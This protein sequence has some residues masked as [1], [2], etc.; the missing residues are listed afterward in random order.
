MLQLMN[1]MYPLEMRVGGMWHGD[2]LIL[3]ELVT[4]G[5]DAPTYNLSV[6]TDLWEGVIPSETVAAI[7]SANGEFD[8]T[9]QNIQKNAVLDPTG[10]KF[11]YPTTIFQDMKFGY[12]EYVGVEIFRDDNKDCNI[13][14][15]YPGPVPPGEN[16]FPLNLS[17]DYRVGHT[18]E[19]H[20]GMKDSYSA[21]DVGRLLNQFWPDNFPP[22]YPN[23]PQPAMPPQPGPR[24]YDTNSPNGGWSMTN[25]YGVGEAIYW[26]SNANY[27]ID[28]GDIRMTDVTVQRGTGANFAENVSYKRGSIVTAGDA[29]VMMNNFPPMPFPPYGL[30]LSDFV[31][32]LQD[33]QVVFWPCYYD[34]RIEDVMNPGHFLP[35]NGVYD[36][37]E[38]I[39]NCA[40]TGLPIV[41]PGF[42][43]LS[44]VTLGG[45][46]YK[47]GSLVQDPDL[48]L[49]QMP[50]YGMDMGLK[51]K[52]RQKK[53]KK[54]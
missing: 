10:I 32:I 9:A 48:W 45:V 34:E 12:R 5:C 52:E 37:G 15:Q 16:L 4:G 31:P 35:P 13:G 1:R 23:G 19:M 28:A 40:Y 7:R 50:I 21:K 6:Q 11:Q 53:K 51:K 43:R 30:D 17:D 33:G 24:F 25:Y 27:T 18:G 14:Y 22:E 3:S 54:G 2:A 46:T 41:A 47:A 26:D 20:I 29:D 8:R 38:V 44:N 42:Q 36:I 49:Y 39:Y